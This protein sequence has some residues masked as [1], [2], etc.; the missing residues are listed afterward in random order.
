MRTIRGEL[1]ELAPLLVLCEDKPADE[2]VREEV[3]I[4]RSVAPPEERNELL[5]VAYMLGTRYLLREVLD[6]IFK[7]E[8][9]AMGDLGI[10]ISPI[11]R[12]DDGTYRY[13]AVFN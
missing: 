12:N 13:E 4:I 8:L 5:A 11:G 6:V 3:E 10:M 2:L 7:E 9:Q 1:P